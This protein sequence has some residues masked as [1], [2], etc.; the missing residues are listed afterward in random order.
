MN[1][2]RVLVVSSNSLFLDAIRMIIRHPGIEIVGS[3]PNQNS[4]LIEQLEALK[5]DI[6]IWEG[7]PQEIETK[8]IQILEKTHQK[9]RIINLNSE[10]N[11]VNIYAADLGTLNSPDELLQMILKE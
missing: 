9:I 4:N 1:T 8:A 3:I 7:E 2:R 6:M 10:N 11:A 5:P